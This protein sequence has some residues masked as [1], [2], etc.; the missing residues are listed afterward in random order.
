M[1]KPS[2]TEFQVESLIHTF[3][4]LWDRWVPAPDTAHNP[5]ALAALA[6]RC[7]LPIQTEPLD[8]RRVYHAMF[9]C[10]G[11]YRTPTAVQRAL[12]T[13]IIRATQSVRNL[14][15]R[16][17]A[18]G[19]NAADDPD[20]WKG[21]VHEVFLKHS[22]RTSQETL[23]PAAGFSYWLSDTQ[24]RR[25]MSTY[26][27]QYSYWQLVGLLEAVVAV[28]V[29]ERSLRTFD[30]VASPHLDQLRTDVSTYL[31]DLI[32]V[33]HPHPSAQPTASSSASPVLSSFSRK[34]EPLG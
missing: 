34:I 21:S 30:G 31:F 1:E 33:L 14:I 16:S 25:L 8:L 20:D 23:S 4:E 22:I 28:L 24:I 2:F 13:E 3:E 7:T 15:L 6:V 11:D 29:S 17:I 12:R 27:A 26:N 10:C 9:E 19:E 5:Y 18:A 32:C